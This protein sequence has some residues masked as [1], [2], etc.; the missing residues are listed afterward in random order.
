L[1]IFESLDNS[2]KKYFLVTI[3][4]EHMCIVVLRVMRMED[5]KTERFLGDRKLIS[6]LIGWKDNFVSFWESGEIRL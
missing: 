6:L 1:D 5:Q 4:L 2:W 3:F